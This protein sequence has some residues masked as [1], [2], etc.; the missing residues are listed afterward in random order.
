[1]ATALSR[2]QAGGE[3]ARIAVMERLMNAIRAALGL[4]RPPP[5][6]ARL[7]LDFKVDF[8]ISK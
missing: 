4:R 2:P 7:F 3:S 5:L 1:M 8:R 6:V